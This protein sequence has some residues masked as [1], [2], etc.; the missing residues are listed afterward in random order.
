MLAD[1]Q[2]QVVA[3][4]RLGIPAI[5]HDECLTGFTASGATIYPTSLGMAATFDPALIGQVGGA[6]EAAGPSRS[7]ESWERVFRLAAASTGLVRP[8]PVAARPSPRPRRC[9]ELADTCA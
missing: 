9:R 4:S 1:R 6:I 5:A 7:G 2:R 3:Q 8:V